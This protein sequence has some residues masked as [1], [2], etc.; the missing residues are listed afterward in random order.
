MAWI[1]SHQSLG[2]HPKLLR[3]ANELGVDK[4][5]AVGHLQYL[6]WWAMDYAKDGDISRFSD[7]E[8]ANAS[9]WRG[10]PKTMSQALRNC[11]WID[12]NG[13]L[14]D[15]VEYAGH[16]MSNRTRQQR[17]REKRKT[18]PLRYG[19]VMST[20]NHTNQPTIPTNQPTN[21]KAVVVIPEDLTAHSADIQAWLAYKGERG[22]TYKSRGLVALWGKI[23][24]IPAHLRRQAIEQSMANNWAGLFALK[25]QG[26]VNGKTERKIG[27][28]GG[29]QPTKQPII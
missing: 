18:L 23:R 14:H 7:F 17:Y 20:S 13:K 8:V 29:F 4:V 15:W 21:K 24:D 11:S 25:Q 28:T 3:L 6:W 1:E 19:D 26:G 12:A 2:R 9:E 10:E 16:Y 22:E 27:V 5:M